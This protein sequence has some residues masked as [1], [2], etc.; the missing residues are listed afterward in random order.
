MFHFSFPFQMQFGSSGC[1]WWNRIWLQAFLSFTL[2][3]GARSSVCSQTTHDTKSSAAQLL[4]KRAAAALRLT[5]THYC[6]RNTQVK[7]VFKE[8]ISKTI[9]DWLLIALLS[10]SIRWSRP[11]SSHCSI[12]VPQQS[13][14]GCSAA[15]GWRDASGKD[16]GHCVWWY[17]FHWMWPVL[18]WARHRREWCLQTMLPVSASYWSTPLL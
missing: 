2:H 3:H 14:P 9:R 10:L 8:Q 18:C 16:P 4:H 5:Y 12:P 15:H 17:H 13:F 6:L 1:C 7:G 11:E